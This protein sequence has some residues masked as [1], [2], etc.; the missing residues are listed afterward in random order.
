MTQMMKWNIFIIFAE[1]TNQ[2]GP[3]LSAHHFVGQDE[4][5]EGPDKLKECR[6]DHQTETQRGQVPQR[7]E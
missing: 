7:K 3:K 2:G 5:P 4:N 1:D 6:G